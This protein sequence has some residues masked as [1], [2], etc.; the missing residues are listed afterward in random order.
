VVGVGLLNALNMQSDVIVGGRIVGG[1]L[2][3]LYSTPRDLCLRIQLMINPIVTRVS[4]PIMA[5]AQ[6]DGDFVRRLYLTT[7][8]MVTSTN[9]PIYAA[10]ALF[11]PEIVHILFGPHWA[12]AAPYLRIIAVAALFR[13]VN[14]PIGSLLYALGETRLMIRCAIFITPV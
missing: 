3:G 2:L 13:C 4:L 11:A 8:R 10:I 6:T 12:G 7:V 1:G 9:F 14:N 5:R